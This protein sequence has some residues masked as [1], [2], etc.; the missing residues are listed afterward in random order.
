[1]EV[2]TWFSEWTALPLQ[3]HPVFDPRLSDCLGV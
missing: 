3:D 2:A 1:M